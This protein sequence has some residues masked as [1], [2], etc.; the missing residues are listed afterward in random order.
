MRK[1]NRLHNKT[2]FLVWARGIHSRRQPFLKL[3]EVDALFIE[4]IHLIKTISDYEEI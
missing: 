2:T 3:G 1:Q 4:Y